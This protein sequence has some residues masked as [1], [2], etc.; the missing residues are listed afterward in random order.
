MQVWHRLQL[1]AHC[2]RNRAITERRAHRLRPLAQGLHPNEQGCSG[3]HGG[4]N[5]DEDDSRPRLNDP[6]RP[7]YKIPGPTATGESSY[8]AVI[9]QNARKVLVGHA[10]KSEGH[11]LC[12]LEAVRA[13]RVIALQLAPF[14]KHPTTGIPIFK[15]AALA[16]SVNLKDVVAPVSTVKYKPKSGD[17][18]NE[19]GLFFRNVFKHEEYN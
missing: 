6:G 14:G 13:S 1:P 8:R 7:R 16:V 11:G 19:K 12:L 15:A 10:F 9:A 5:D 4:W 17:L 3:L 2:Q 18:R